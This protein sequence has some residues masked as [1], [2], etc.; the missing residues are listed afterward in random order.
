MF[1]HIKLNVANDCDCFPS[2]PRFPTWPELSHLRNSIL[3]YR[4][5][6]YKDWAFPR[7]V[8][9]LGLRSKRNL[10]NK[11]M[12]G[13]NSNKAK[14]GASNPCPA[15]SKNVYPSEQVFGAD[16]KPWH[17]Q[18]IRCSVMGCPW[19][20]E[21]DWYSL[22]SMPERYWHGNANELPLLEPMTVKSEIF[23][24]SKTGIRV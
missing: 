16:R 23:L 5:K 7:A 24:P 10:H 19:V 12:V 11:K 8:A 2:A 4:L 14:W 15:C 17:R 9:S 20:S 18:C 1:L 3:V 6:E 21:T 13:D 22:R